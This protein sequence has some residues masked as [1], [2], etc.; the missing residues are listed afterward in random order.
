MESVN[1]VRSIRIGTGLMVLAALQWG[2]IGV[3]G[4]VAMAGSVP[5]LTVAFWR[6]ALGALLF[7]AHARWVGAG[8]LRA[9]DRA[10][11]AGLGFGGVALMYLAY[12]NCVQQ[13]GAALA[14]ILL[15]SAPLWVAVGAWIFW[16]E[17]PGFRGSLPLGSTLAG[18][19]TVAMASGGGPQSVRVSGTALGW[20]LVSG[21]SYSLYYLLGRRLFARN[22]PARVLAWALTIGAVALFPFV[23]VVS[24]PGRAWAATAFLA[25]VC[26]YGAYFAYAGGLQRLGP[27]RAATIATLEPV[28]A[29]VAAYHVWGEQLSAVGLAGAAAVIGGVVWSA[30]EDAGDDSPDRAS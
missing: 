5:P 21:L 6:A 19:V 13:G 9:E 27:S 30:R 7:A 11:T 14:A 26:T 22:S 4:R 29:V 10:A 3:A 16:K 28:V 25:V 24:M 20:G 12:L 1:R 8:P 15:Y 23:S 17:R 2:M 18:V